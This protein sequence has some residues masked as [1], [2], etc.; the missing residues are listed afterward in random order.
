MV[1]PGRRGGPPTVTEDGMTLLALVESPDHVCCRYRVRLHLR[2]FSMTQA[3][4]CRIKVLIEAPC[5][6]RS[7]SVGHGNLTR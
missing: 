6:A 4:P 2:P 1:G 5:F 3:G 7:T